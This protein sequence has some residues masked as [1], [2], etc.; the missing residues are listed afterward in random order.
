MREKIGPNEAEPEGFGGSKVEGDNK[1]WPDL[2]RNPSGRG[3]FY[4]FRCHSSLGD[5]RYPSLVVPRTRKNRLPSPPVPICRYNLE[6][7]GFALT[8]YSA[9]EGR[10]D[11]QD[12]GEKFGGGGDGGE[13]LREG[14]A[15]MGS[16]HLAE[17]NLRSMS[18]L[19][20]VLIRCRLFT[21]MLGATAGPVC[22]DGNLFT[23]RS[24]G[25]V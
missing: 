23:R 18:T 10:N 4:R 16:N 7:S 22:L 13:A 12:G 19:E 17:R 1:V 9:L 21:R 24:S 3:R 11:L 25:R 8:S 15:F 20:R 2:L 14:S 5:T 6:L